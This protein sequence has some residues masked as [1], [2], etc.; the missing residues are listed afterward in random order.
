MTDARSALAAAAAVGPFFALEEW[1]PD[2]GWRPLTSLADGSGALAERVEA[3]REVIAGRAR[4]P[5]DS[6]ER[7]VAASIVFLGLAARLLSPAVAAA[8]LGGT[9]PALGISSLWWKPVEGGPWPIATDSMAGAPADIDGLVEGLVVG[10]VDGA[11]NGTILPVL[12]AFSSTFQLS[13]QVLWGNVASSLGGALGLLVSGRPDRAEVADDLIDGLL[14]V[15]PLAGTGQFVAP[16]PSSP[17]R[18]FVRRSCCL[19]YRVPGAGTCGDCVL[20]PDDV[21]RQQWREALRP[22]R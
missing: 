21:R 10:L 20:T 9:V 11:L 12:Q 7:R 14:R 4:R 13:E 18:F 2:A 17:R 3:A 16:D 1:A 15:A 6:I 5:V 8:A 19:F 22:A